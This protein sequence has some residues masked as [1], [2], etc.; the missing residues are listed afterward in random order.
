MWAQNVG[1]W[2]QFTLNTIVLNIFSITLI[3][4]LTLTPMV[5]CIPDVDVSPGA[6]VPKT[7]PLGMSVNLKD[8]MYWFI[9]T[10]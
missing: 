5:D 6:G 1:L 10:A 7:C 8:I 3:L 2:M 4:Q 9:P